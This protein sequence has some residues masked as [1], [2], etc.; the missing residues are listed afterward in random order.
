MDNLRE[1]LKNCTKCPLHCTRTNVVISDG[2]VSADIMLIGEAPGADEDK[3]GI[4]FVGRAGKLLN[5]F[6]IKAGLDRK[7]DLYIANTV[8][9][10]PPENRKPTK[11]EKIAC[12]DN[13]KKQIDMVKPKVIILCG[14]TAME[15]FIKDKKL[16]IS[17]ARGQVFDLNG[18]KLVPIFHPSYLLRQHSMQKGSPRD[19][20]L[21][22]LKMVKALVNSCKETT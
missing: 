18:I 9:C 3:T 1:K 14:A 15:S 17:K 10:R 5:E 16:T 13:L 7:K 8:K 11:E 19:L 2:S 22:D 6:L 20:M 12:E 21:E 4:P